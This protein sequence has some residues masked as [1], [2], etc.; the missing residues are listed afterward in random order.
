MKPSYSNHQL[1]E[2][3]GK[4]SYD[5]DESS[6]DSLATSLGSR[7]FSEDIRE[8][9]PEL[10][11]AMIKLANGYEAVRKESETLELKTC[12]SKLV[13]DS[14]GRS[15]LEKLKR[16]SDMYDSLCVDSIVQKL[17]RANIMKASNELVNDFTAMK[18]TCAK[19]RMHSLSLYI[20]FN[21]EVFCEKNDR[22]NVDWCDSN[23][24][25]LMLE[26][27]FIFVLTHKL[28]TGIS[29]IEITSL[30]PDRKT[31]S[32][33]RKSELPSDYELFSFVRVSEPKTVQTHVFDELK[34]SMI[35]DGFYSISPAN[36]ME[37]IKTKAKELC[38][39]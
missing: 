12:G 8:Y 29:K 20:R 37:A 24:E 27:G 21:E 13:A 25:M 28:M 16:E 17:E 1:N 6:N 39:L 7:E 31:D 22:N 10:E 23:A 33:N 11:I 36:A 4:P 34:E 18:V 26:E 14:F 30:N 35:D 15:F 32:I 9:L 19:V 5:W 2:L 3:F 38:L